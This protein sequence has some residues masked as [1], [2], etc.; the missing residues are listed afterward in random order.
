M[1]EK[2]KDFIL[3]NKPYNTMPSAYLHGSLHM[4]CTLSLSLLLP[5]SARLACT[6]TVVLSENS[7]GG[8][9]GVGGGGALVRPLPIL[10][11][12]SIFLM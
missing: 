1:I 4:V 9:R 8:F 10:C 5:Y 3:Y 2:G 6:H 11:Q 7:S 12:F